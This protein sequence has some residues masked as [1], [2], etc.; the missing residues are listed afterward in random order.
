MRN[1]GLVDRDTVKFLGYNS[2]LDNIQA[3]IARIKL[4]YLY[5]WNERFIEIANIYSQ[6][7]LIFDVG[8]FILRLIVR[9]VLI[10][11]F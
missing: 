9:S 6:E 8:I 5:K 1:H 2:R 10:I 4:P 11:R 7:F 3:A